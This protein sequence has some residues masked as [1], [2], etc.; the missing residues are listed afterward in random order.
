MIEV[1]ILYYHR[2]MLFPFIR[3]VLIYFTASSASIGVHESNSRF[4]SPPEPM[5]YEQE[6]IMRLIYNGCPLFLYKKMCVL[7]TLNL[8]IKCFRNPK[9]HAIGGREDVTRAD[10]CDGFQNSNIRLILC[11]TCMQL[12]ISQI[13]TFSF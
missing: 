12:D 2:P 5:D 7:L 1:S 8:S 10:N 6:Y 4:M 9:I 11:E 13:I 3:N